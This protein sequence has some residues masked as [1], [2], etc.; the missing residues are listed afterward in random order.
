[1]GLTAAALDQ[2]CREL[3]GPGYA[4]TELSGAQAVLSRYQRSTEDAI[5]GHRVLADRWV[6]KA[7]APGRAVRER[8]EATYRRFDPR[9]ADA[10]RALSPSLLDDCH[11]RELAIYELAS[12][13]L[14]AIAPA[15]ERVWRDPAADI[16]VIVMERLTGV[17]HASTLDDLD[18]WQPD[19]IA[20]A[21]AGIARVHGELLG[22]PP[23]C[24]V[25][26]GELHTPSLRAYQAALLRYNADAFPALFD[27]PR[28]RRLEALL[29]A[30]PRRLR[31]IAQRPLTLIHG[32]FTPRNICLRADGRLCAYDW[33]LAQAH[34]PA[35]DVCELLCY[36][37]DPARG[38]RHPITTRLLEGYRG[39]LAAATGQ[40]IE[41]EAFVHELALAGA[42]LC[43][44][45]LLV[46]GITHQ[47]LGNRRYFERMV[48][49]AFAFMEVFV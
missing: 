27:A 38:W 10:Q 41:P 34:L 43:T 18:V 42:E 49:N 28:V 40:P 7:K 30:T 8:L 5:V 14:R 32:D 12:P 39:A 2:L 36:V 24:V 6:I 22:A 33:E 21:L 31:A 4:L 16:Y 44:F 47:L 20:A 11:T 25:P 23:A 19:D 17:R 46:Q 1:M 3:A 29:E 13:A 45:K 35:R 15:I 37:L 48:H 9:L 26:F